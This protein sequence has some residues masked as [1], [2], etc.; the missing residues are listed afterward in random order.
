MATPH[1]IWQRQDTRG[2]QCPR[3]VPATKREH[4][5]PNMHPGNTALPTL[6]ERPSGS[7]L[8]NRK[9]AVVEHLM[10]APP[11]PADLDRTPSFGTKLSRFSSFHRKAG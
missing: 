10:L 11:S 1:A 8:G 3:T 9:Q 2:R 4:L 5:T 6:S 7:S